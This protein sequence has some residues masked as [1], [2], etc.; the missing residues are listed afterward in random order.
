MKEHESIILFLCGDVM[1]GRGIDQVLAHP[2]DPELYETYVRDARR[3]MMLAEQANGPIHKQVSPAYIWGDAL[4]VLDSIRP[5]L[6]IINL[7]TSITTS[8]DYLPKGINYRMHPK[9][10]DVLT[11]AG[12][13]CSVLANNHVLDWGIDGLVE[14]LATLEKAGIRQAG[15]GRNRTRAMT[16]AVFDLP[17]RNRVLV[18]AYGYATSGV[19]DAWAAAEEKP[20]INLLPD[21]S[22]NT[23]QQIQKEIAAIRQPGDIVVISLHWGGNWGY[24]IPERQQRFAHLL[25]EQAGVDLIHG[26][27]SHHVKGIEVYQNKLILYGCGDFIND[28]EGIKGYE[29]FRDDLTLMYFPRISSSSGRLEE[30]RL[31]PMQIKRFQTVYPGRTDVL[32]LQEVLNRE[33][34]SLNTSVRLN[35]DN[36]LNLSWPEE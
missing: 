27:S 10:I 14:T 25:I 20:G 33:G 18:F 4:K 32:W 8:D 23:V 2:S 30:L 7:E 31:V 16:P 35:D 3:Y 11:A 34:K 5:D 21:L 15:A 1:P 13:D 19:P 36:S 26:H 24:D 9:N 17:G 28:Y 12:I 29:Q 6:R 22:Q